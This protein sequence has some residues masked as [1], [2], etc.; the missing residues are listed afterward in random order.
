[1]TT[2]YED[3]GK[4]GN[5]KFKKNITFFELV[6]SLTILDLLSRGFPTNSVKVSFENTFPEGFVC[7]FTC[8]F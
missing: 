7:D 1:M 2:K 4:E 8:Y 3:I 5:G 6:F